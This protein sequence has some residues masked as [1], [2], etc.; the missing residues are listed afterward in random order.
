[1]VASPH[2]NRVTV[3]VIDLAMAA[4]DVTEA[5]GRAGRIVARVSGRAIENKQSYG[6]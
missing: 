5:I 4:P 2:T 3:S 1:M 6:I